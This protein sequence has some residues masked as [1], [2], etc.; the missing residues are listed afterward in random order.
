MV[1][2]GKVEGNITANQRVELR[3]SG[4]VIG[5]I[6]TQRIL[7]EE[8]AIF[9]GKLDTAESSKGEKADQSSTRSQSAVTTSANPAA[10]GTAA[11]G[12]LLNKV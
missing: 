9:K 1:I 12:P 10:S 11:Q 6:K 5:D 2:Q 7:I 4:V 3:N 8:G